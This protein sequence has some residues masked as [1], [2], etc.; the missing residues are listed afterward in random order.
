MYD[1]DLAP[2]IQNVAQEKLK[3][4]RREKQKG[5]TPPPGKA[6]PNAPGPLAAFQNK[7]LT[8]EHGDEN[9]DP[10]REKEGRVA[11][12]LRERQMAKRKAKADMLGKAGISGA[13][14]GT[15]QK[16]RQIKSLIRVIRG[17]TLVGTSLG[18]VF[19]CLSG[20]FLS[21]VGEWAIAKFQIVPGYKM[22]DPEDPF[23][24]LD[25]LLWYGGWAV[26]AAALVLAVVLAYFV[27]YLTE[28][29]LEAIKFGIG[30]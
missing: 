20:L 30:L 17:G 19:F 9:V 29:P 23:V 27:V 11:K 1:E 15:L 12:A 3:Q 22:F 21:L 24:L 25:K 16:V 2:D 10:N 28:N 13:G 18:D 4:A 14:K 6:A 7:N 26:I 8:A 5:K